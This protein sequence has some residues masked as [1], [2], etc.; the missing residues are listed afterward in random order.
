MLT[1]RLT[2]TPAHTH[3]P[4]QDAAILQQ[5]FAL[6][7]AGLFD[8]Q[9]VFGLT[10]LAA[11]AIQ[12]TAAGPHSTG[13]SGAT[14]VAEPPSSSSSGNSSLQ[15]RR[16]GLAALYERFGFP[17]PNKAAVS[18]KFDRQP[19]CGTPHIQACRGH[20]NHGPSCP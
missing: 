5:Q 16:I 9:V 13:S 14:P 11:A 7:L 3:M 20:T 17:H 4:L 12:P 2:P 8:T 6:R 18:A 10:S 1:R 15:L 19:R